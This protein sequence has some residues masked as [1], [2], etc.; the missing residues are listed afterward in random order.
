MEW[1]LIDEKLVA[2]FNFK[3]QTELAEFVLK[4]AK[5]GDKMHHHPDYKI[6]KA[7][8]VEITL[9]TYD[10]NAITALDYNLSDFISSQFS[11]EV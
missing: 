7:F 8:T 4:I 9:F 10:K 3:S 5:Q 1:N 2:N 6:F 11:L